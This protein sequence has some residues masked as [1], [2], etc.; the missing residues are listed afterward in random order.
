MQAEARLKDSGS[1]PDPFITQ[2]TSS[3]SWRG[4]RTRSTEKCYT[5]SQDA[6][7]CRSAIYDCRRLPACGRSSLLAF[8]TPRRLLPSRLDQVSAPLHTL[9]DALSP[10][11]LVDCT[12]HSRWDA[13]IPLLIKCRGFIR[14]GIIHR[15][16]RLL[17]TV[18]KSLNFLNLLQ[19]ICHS[20]CDTKVSSLR[21]AETICARCHA[22][23]LLSLGPWYT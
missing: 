1:W 9:T 8:S 20:G 5:Q 6:G 21:R 17:S 10:P 11:P 3:C 4:R 18:D 23:N 2:D 14:D 13:R 16:V 12:V 22:V 7:H 15:A 19:C